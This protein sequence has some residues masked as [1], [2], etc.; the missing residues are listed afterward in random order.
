MY[1]HHIYNNIQPCQEDFQDIVDEINKEKNDTKKITK[2]KESKLMRMLFN[3][4]KY[5]GGNNKFSN[6]W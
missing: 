3:Q 4:N 1:K 5:F 6:P 2:L